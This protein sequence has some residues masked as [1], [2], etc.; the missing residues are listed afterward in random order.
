MQEYTELRRVMQEYTELCRNILSY[1]GKYG[2]VIPF[3][4][5]HEGPLSAAT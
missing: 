2:V 5:E 1:A 4:A 3:C